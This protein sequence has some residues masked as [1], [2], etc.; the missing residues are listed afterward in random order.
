V[1][2]ETGERGRIDILKERG[3]ALLSRHGTTGLALALSCLL[4]AVL[5]WGVRGEVLSGSALFGL[6]SSST[7]VSL[8]RV[9]PLTVMPTGGTSLNAGTGPAEQ[10]SSAPGGATPESASATEVSDREQVEGAGA[11]QRLSSNPMPQLG[12]PLPEPH[13]FTPEE[14]SVKPKLLS[15]AGASEPTFI[16]DILPLPVLVQLLINEEGD[17]D[18]VILGE[19]FL[20]D[21]AKK[22]IVE[23]FSGMKFSPGVLGAF[24]V[25]SQLKIVVNLDPTIPVN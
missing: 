5:L 8:I 10:S 13:Y 3:L 1:G 20:S 6:H 24:P 25:K 2:L 18:G 22:Y 15:D 7:L 9:S 12:G 4:H 14:L 23:S 19:N 21:A 16:P 17:V 11:A